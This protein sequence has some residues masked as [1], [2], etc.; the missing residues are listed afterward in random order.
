MKR[1]LVVLIL[2]ILFCITSFAENKTFIKEGESVVQKDQSVNQ[3]IDYLKQ[4]LARQ[5]QE[6][7][8]KFITSELV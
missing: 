3:V 8:G 1:I 4:K 5:A 6:Q 2:S 7:A